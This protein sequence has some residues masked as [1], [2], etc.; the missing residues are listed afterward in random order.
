M[1]TAFVN[2]HDSVVLGAFGTG[3]FSNDPRLVA[4]V[5]NQ[6]FKHEFRGCFRKVVLAIMKFDT[7]AQG[8]GADDLKEQAFRTHFIDNTNPAPGKSA[9]PHGWGAKPA[10]SQSHCK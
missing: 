5:F 6:V 3:A 10:A 1:G 7:N 8:T 2:G 9:Q 4:E